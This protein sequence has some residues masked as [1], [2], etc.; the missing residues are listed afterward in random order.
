MKKTL[1]FSLFLL[2][3]LTLSAQSLSISDICNGL[4]KNPNIKG[5][6]TQTKIINSNGRKLKSSGTFIICPFGIMWKTLKPFPSTIVVTNDSMIQLGANG[7]KTVHSG[8]DNKMFESIA[9]SLSSV[10]TGDKKT[11]EEN[12]NI[13]LS[14]ENQSWTIVL[15]PKDS[16]IAAV[17][18]KMTLKGTVNENFTSIT[19]NS[20]EMFEGN[21]TVKYELENHEYPEELTQDERENFVTK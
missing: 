15:Q 13:E 17:M 19:M 7:K 6:F 20:M 12:F 4:S 8:A 9:T 1:L 16:T 21:N 5:D 3:T 10:F 14:Q 2:F 18:Q 11:L